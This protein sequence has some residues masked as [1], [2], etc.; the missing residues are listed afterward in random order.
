VKRRRTLVGA[1]VLFT[2]AIL[3]GACATPSATAPGAGNSASTIIGLG[4][5][6]TTVVLHVGDRLLLSLEPIQGQPWLIT[7]YPQEILST[8]STNEGAA[9]RTFTARAPGE[10]R[11]VA[12]TRAGC[13]PTQLRHPYGAP[14]RPA[15]PPQGAAAPEKPPGTTFSVTVIVTH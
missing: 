8:D 10:G 15:G 12:F 9:A 2:G 3:G 14:C 13:D 6:G 1:S 11:I 5:A 7:Q 4:D